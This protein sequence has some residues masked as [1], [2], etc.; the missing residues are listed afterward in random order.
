MILNVHTRV[1]T[2]KIKSLHTVS[3][4]HSCMD[5]FSG[6][7]FSYFCFVAIFDLM[8]P[9]VRCGGYTFL[10]THTCISE[11]GFQMLFTVD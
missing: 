6:H 4:F 2:R 10:T 7:F 9:N 5:G 3:P 1:V 11:N 8:T